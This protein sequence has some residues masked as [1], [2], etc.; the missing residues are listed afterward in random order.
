[1]MCFTEHAPVRALIKWV[2][3]EDGWVGAS[4]RS[5]VCGSKW[6]KEGQTVEVEDY[7]VMCY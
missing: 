2:W 5:V 4:G 7:I 3:S 1:M 6:L